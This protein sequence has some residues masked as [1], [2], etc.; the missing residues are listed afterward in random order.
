M[1]AWP[2]LVKPDGVTLAD[3]IVSLAKDYQPQGLAMVAISSNSIAT[4]PQDGPEKMCEDAKQYGVA[5]S[6][7]SW[8]PAIS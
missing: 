2:L 5:F 8:H 6:P 7:S 4:H 1:H 3:A